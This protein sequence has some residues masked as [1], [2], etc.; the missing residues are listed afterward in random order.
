MHSVEQAIH[1]LV[2]GMALIPQGVD[3]GDFIL[4]GA[5][6]KQAPSRRAN[7]PSILALIDDYLA[8]Q[9]HIAPSY[10]TP[11]RSTCATSARNSASGPTRRST[12]SPTA[13]WSSTSRPG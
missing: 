5:T 4:S 6:L 12:G 9:A 8:H 2:T 7:V 10:S 13:T 3:P 1:R 11:R